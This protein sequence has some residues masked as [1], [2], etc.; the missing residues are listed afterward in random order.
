[1]DIYPMHLM[2]AI[3]TGDIEKM[4]G[5]GITELTEEDVALCEFACTSKNPLQT[6]LREGLNNLK[7]QL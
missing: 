3:I 6:L 5:L 4:E 2:K 7:E 1:M